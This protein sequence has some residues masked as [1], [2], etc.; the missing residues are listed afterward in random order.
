[1]NIIYVDDNNEIIGSG[2]IQQAYDKGV[3]V[4]IA[5][6]FLVNDA[7]EVL[8]QKRSQKVASLP[9]RWDQSAAGHVDE[10][11]SYEAAAYR[12]LSEEVGIDEAKLTEIARYYTEESDEP[13]IKRR[14]NALYIGQYD[15]EVNID[16]Y[17]VSEYRWIDIDS[18]KAAIAASPDDYTEG[19][20]EALK[21]YQQKL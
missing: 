7:G 19:F 6:V 3:A 13:F 12:E 20:R 9:G 2:P 8:I 1:M 17:E 5:R 4:R 21:V 15:G 11:E 10:G 18:L 14:F 16:N